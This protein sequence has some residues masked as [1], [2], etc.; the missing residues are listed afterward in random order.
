MRTRLFIAV[1]LL[2]AA[3][4]AVVYQ[5]RVASISAA[6]EDPIDIAWQAVHARPGDSSAWMALGEVQAAV[7]QWT[8]AEHA[9]RTAIRLGDPKGLVYARLGF[10]LYARGRDAE[11]QGFLL[12]AKYRGATVPMLDA[13][14]AALQPSGRAQ[15]QPQEPL[16]ESRRPEAWSGPTPDAGT[17]GLDASFMPYVPPPPPQPPASAPS[18]PVSPPLASPRDEVQVLQGECDLRLGRSGR[19]RGVYFA[20]AYFGDT[21][22]RLIFDTGASITLITEDLAHRIG[23]R[24]DTQHMIR[25]ITAN[26]RV[27]MPT[28]V[29]GPIEIGPKRLARLRVA[30][31]TDCLGE[32]ADGLLGLDLQ[33]AF[34]MQLDLG[35]GIVRFAGCEDE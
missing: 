3:G 6:N 21:P 1:A 9:Y 13:T 22:T 30:V 29:V 5:G 10:L 35:A 16:A 8:A 4:G 25:A 24:I 28:A 32:H 23:A 7:D 34:R 18:P 15:P 27:N 33:A 14:L 12:Q 19:G 2:A 11:A 17:P 31:C 20:E 26:G